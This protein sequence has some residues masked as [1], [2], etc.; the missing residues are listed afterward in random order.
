FVSD[1]ESLF[2]A[3]R[4]HALEGVMAKRKEGKYITGRRSDIWLKVKVKNSA[5]CCVIGYTPG[6]GNRAQT[7]GSLQIAEKIGNELWY[8]GKVGTGCDDAL[9]KE[10]LQALKKQKQVKKG[11]DMKGGKVVDE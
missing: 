2:E 8:R 1:G 3:A 4:E 5:E 9:M 6:K 10:I 11:P 7:F